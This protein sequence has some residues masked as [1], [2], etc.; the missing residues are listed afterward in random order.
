MSAD[1]IVFC[2]YALP[3]ADMHVKCLLKRSEQQVGIRKS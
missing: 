2:G 1:R 3:D